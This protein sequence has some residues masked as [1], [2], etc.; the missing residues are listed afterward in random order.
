MGGGGQLEAGNTPAS[1]GPRAHPLNDSPSTRMGAQ[2]PQT[3]HSGASSLCGPTAP[4]WLP[5]RE[6]HAG[7]RARPKIAQS[8][9][10]R[11]NSTN[12]AWGKR[13]GDGTGLGW[14][15]FAISTAQQ[16]YLSHH[17]GAHRVVGNHQLPPFGS[18]TNRNSGS[19]GQAVHQG[20][21]RREMKCTASPAADE[22]RPADG[23][24]RAR[25]HAQT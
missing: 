10:L 15:G 19:W 4:A 23:G 16:T 13:A 1:H 2:A 6:A 7:H 24:G 18:F 12:G 14:C 17:H 5:M 8:R 20:S 3:S 9:S 21:C 22:P 11:L 25:T